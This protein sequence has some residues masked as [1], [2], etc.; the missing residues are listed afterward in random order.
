MRSWFTGRLTAVRRIA[1][2]VAFAAIVLQPQFGERDVTTDTS[3][4]EV[5]V[6]LDRTRSMAALDYGQ[7]RPRIEGVHRDLEVLLEELPGTRFGLLTW[8]TQARLELPFTTDHA[9]FLNAVEA[10]RLQDPFD[11]PGTRVDTPLR[12]LVQ[13]LKDAEERYPGRDRMLLFISDGEN[14]TGGAPTSYERI[15]PYLAGGY[16]LGYGTPGGAPMPLAGDLSDARGYVQFEGSNAISR[17]DRKALRRLA[18]EA[19]VELVTRTGPGGMRQL[20]AE[21]TGELTEE[22]DQRVTVPIDWTWLAGLLLFPLLLWELHGHWRRLWEARAALGTE[23]GRWL[24]GEV[25][26]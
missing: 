3:D 11:G 26:S 18:R 25:K 19:G 6:V 1:I 2:V 13:E 10:A 4:V 20:A 12:P 17:T 7:G 14:T 24:P 23:R 8:A 5:L 16:V 15:A 9:A 21:F 22:S